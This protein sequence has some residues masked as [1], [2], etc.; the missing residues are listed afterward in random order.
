MPEEEEEVTP[1]TRIE[2]L[3][4]ELSFSQKEKEDPLQGLSSDD[5]DV[6]R[7]LESQATYSRLLYGKCY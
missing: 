4:P 5:M 7:Q 2:K 6:W 3:I 1:Q